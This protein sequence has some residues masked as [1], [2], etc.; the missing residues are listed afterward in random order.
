[1]VWKKVIFTQKSTGFIVIMAGDKN[2][3]NKK[4]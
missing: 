2:D 4:K 3:L 1:M